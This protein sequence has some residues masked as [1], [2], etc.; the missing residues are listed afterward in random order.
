MCSKVG[1]MEKL[2]MLKLDYLLKHSNQHKTMV[3]NTR[4]KV[5]SFYFKHAH[6]NHG[7]NWLGKMC[8]MVICQI[9]KLGKMCNMVICQILELGKLTKQLFW[10]SYD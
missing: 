4:V 5:G 8:N 2:T 3:G 7:S 6:N 1:R 9:L 10:W